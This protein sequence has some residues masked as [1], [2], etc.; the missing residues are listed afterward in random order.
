MLQ[1]NNY[2]WKITF[3]F[4]W[5]NNRGSQYWSWVGKEKFML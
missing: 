1:I 4:I 5:R 3:I 2:F